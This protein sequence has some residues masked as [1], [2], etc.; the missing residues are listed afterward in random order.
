[1]F[2][3][4][5]LFLVSVLQYEPNNA[6]AKE[7]YPFIVEKLQLSEYSCNSTW[8]WQQ[9]YWSLCVCVF[10]VCIHVSS[11]QAVGPTVNTVCCSGSNI[12]SLNT[13]FTA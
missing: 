6:T 1:M 11:T 10:C 8:L 12:V 2:L 5:V 4:F 13:E 3:S 9:K 7:F